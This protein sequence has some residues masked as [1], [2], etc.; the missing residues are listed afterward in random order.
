MQGHGFVVLVQWPMP[1]DQQSKELD[2]LEKEDVITPVQFSDW[3]APIVPVMK[4]D[5][6]TLRIC[7]DFKLTVNQASKLDQYPIYTSDPGSLHPQ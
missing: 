2:H 6:K 4:K 1:C 5:G 7:G 3:A